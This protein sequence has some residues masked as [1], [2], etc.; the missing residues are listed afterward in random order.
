M[1][2]QRNVAQTPHLITMKQLLVVHISGVFFAIITNFM[3]PP[4]TGLG[5]LTTLRLGI[6]WGTRLIHH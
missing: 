3:L 4:L 2:T 6:N 5:H 1:S